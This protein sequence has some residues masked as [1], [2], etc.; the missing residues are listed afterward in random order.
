MLNAVEVLYLH[1]INGRTI[2]DVDQYDF[3][4]KQYGIDG[5]TLFNQ[6]LN[7]N[8]IYE[9]TTPA[10][11][12][13]K[14]TVVKLKDVLRKSGIKISGRKQVLI[15]RIVE[16]SDIIDF[17]DLDLKGVYL[18]TKDFEQHFKNTSFINYFHFNGHITVQEAYQ[19]Y[20][21][22]QTLHPEA[23]ITAVLNENIRSGM[24]KSNKYE[25]VKSHLLLSNFYRDTLKDNAQYVFH[26]NHFS[27]LIILES[28]TRNGHTNTGDPD[29]LDHYTIE[30]YRH[31]LEINHWNKTQLYQ[32]ILETTRT[33]PYP[34]ES[35]KEAASLII[36][37]LTAFE[38]LYSPS[39]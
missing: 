2:D 8:V 29:I 16:H 34:A 26:L 27:V 1:Y 35:I 19:Y 36:R 15:S 18:V 6:L 38:S 23:V 32:N 20:V 10:V 39:Y 17:H 21:N 30:K 12:L 4:R 33:L 3:W 14:L 9:D 28:V 22:H 5:K 31:V 11:T 13:S 37:Q 24:K 7:K 25:A